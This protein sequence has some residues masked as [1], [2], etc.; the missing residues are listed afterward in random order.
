MKTEPVVTA[1]V[2]SAFLVAL[3]VFLVGRNVLEWSPEDIENFG[4]MAGLGVSL[5]FGIIPLI[6]SAVA[7]K[8]T[9][10]LVRP[11]DKDLKPLMTEAEWK[12]L[13]K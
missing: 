6:A 8:Y 1:G 7:R 5:L 12:S 2:V 11:R 10:S 13:S 4:V 3:V 9:T